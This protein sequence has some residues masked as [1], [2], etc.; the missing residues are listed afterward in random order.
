M[1]SAYDLY[2]VQTNFICICLLAYVYIMYSKDGKN[3][4]EAR[5]FKKLIWLL[6]AY[7]GVD[8]IAALCKNRVFLFDREVLYAANIIYITIPLWMS[9]FWSR[10]VIARL[11]K[12]GYKNGFVDKLMLVVAIVGTALMLSTPLTGFGFRLDEYNHYYRNIGAYTVPIVTL[13]Y[14]IYIT[15]RSVHNGYK[16][17]RVV[18]RDN[19]LTISMF[20]FPTLVCSIIQVLVYGCTIAQVGFTGSVLLVFSTNQLHLILKDELTGLNNRRDFERYIN[21]IVESS[22]EIMVAMIDLDGF[23]GVNDKYGHFEGDR[24]LQDVSLILTNAVRLTD[25]GLFLARYGGDEF[26]VVGTE[27]NEEVC[28]LLKANIETEVKRHNE[29]YERDYR[30]SLSV[31]T[32][33]GKVDTENDIN[34]IIRKADDN[35]YTIKNGRALFPEKEPITF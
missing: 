32:A 24:A 2:Y 35:M 11:R 31:G 27:S 15:V 13:A 3:M 33:F 12:S 20:V 17:K 23:K 25:R 1:V 5:W 14:L 34:D 19:A 7:C 4:Y 22:Q 30:I 6:L 8:M 10:Y 28:D 21:T 16:S 26:V 9:L 18:D 29:T